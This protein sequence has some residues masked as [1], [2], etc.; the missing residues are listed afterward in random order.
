LVVAAMAR[1]LAVA[2]WYLM[3]GRWTRLEE[4]DDRLEIKV[5]KII[6]AVGTKG[7]EKL[8]KTRKAFREEIHQSLKNGRVYVLD[9]DRMFVPKPKDQPKAEA[10]VA[11]S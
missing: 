3:M 11:T 1:K 7:L 8:Q 4:I 2:V 10:A 6:G 5:T 9:P